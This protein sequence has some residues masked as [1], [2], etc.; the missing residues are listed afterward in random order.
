MMVRKNGRMTINVLDKQ[1]SLA[2]YVARGRR[3][4]TLI[5]LIIAMAIF[6]TVIVGLYKVYDVQFKQQ[7]KEY[8]LAESEMELGIAKNLIERDLIMA[9]F[10]IMDDYATYSTPTTPKTA[11]SASEGGT[12]PDTL[13][14][15]G[16]ALGIKSRATMEWATVGD[17][18]PMLSLS[19]NDD[20]REN[21]QAGDRVIITNPSGSTESNLKTLLTQTDW[22]FT[23]TSSTTAP[24]GYSTHAPFTNLQK[25]DIIYALNVSGDLDGDATVPYYTVTYSLGG[26]SPSYCA[27]GTNMKS[28][29]RAESRTSTTPTG[30]DPVMSCVRDFEVAFGITDNT[31]SPDP[32]DAKNYNINKWDN[33]GVIVNGYSQIELRQRLKQIRVY[34]LVQDGNQDLNYTYVNPDPNASA[35]D[36]IRVG[37]LSLVGG[38]TGR[39]VTLSAAQRNYRWRLLTIVVTPRNIRP[40]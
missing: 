13:T 9:G 6:A 33:G 23:Y 32:A 26:T 29:L 1:T 40:L 28:L 2:C 24:I 17:T 30:G 10:G 11:V 20:P 14:L 7:T 16:T 38:T 21:I 3:G 4:F 31:V 39:D 25:G 34:I 22:L 18:S 35:P 5:E 12:N 15:R 27:P 37:E 19:T 8:R 36:T